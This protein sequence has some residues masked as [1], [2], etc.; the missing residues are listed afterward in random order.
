MTS[1]GLRYGSARG[2]RV[3][4]QKPEEGAKGSGIIMNHEHYHRYKY[5]Y[6][7]W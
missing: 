5:V 2:R 4:D 7:V 6:I 3:V 1:T